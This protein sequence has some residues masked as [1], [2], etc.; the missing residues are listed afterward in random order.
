MNPG[1]LD[2][3]VTIQARTYAADGTGGRT[4]TW[5]DTFDCWAE[6]L[7]QK[8][9]EIMA[10]GADRAADERQFRIRYKARL[11]SGNH[12]VVYQGA[13]Y[14]ILGITEEGRQDMLLL[15]CRAL[16]ELSHG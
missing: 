16:Q 3:R 5:E 11:T 4:E 7:A 6:A 2:R 8:P 14:N 9:T 15:T 10:A 13:Y 12:R 1:K